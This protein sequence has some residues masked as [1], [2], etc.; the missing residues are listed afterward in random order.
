M[1]IQFYFGTDKVTAE[2]KEFSIRVNAD[3]DTT[4]RQARQ[5][6]DV[7]STALESRLGGEYWPDQTAWNSKAAEVLG[8]E[9]L[10]PDPAPQPA[11][12][13]DENKSPIIY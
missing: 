3:G 2:L 4:V 1:K 6:E 7:L 13:F 8:A 11:P 12:Q 10:E 9:V 5:I